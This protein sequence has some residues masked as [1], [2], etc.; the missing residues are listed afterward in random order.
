MNLPR[1][2]YNCGERWTLSGQPGRGESC[3]KCRADLRV[4]L[5]CAHYDPHVAQQCRERRAEPVL[6]K[7][8]GNFCEYFEFAVRTWTPKASD[9]SR[10]SA[11][12]ERFNKLFGD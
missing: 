7:H 1:H 9:N 6:E 8:V 10:E 12:R 4:C 11:A 3:M 2:C 5:N